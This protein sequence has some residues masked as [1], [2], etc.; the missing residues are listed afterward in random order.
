MSHEC[1]RKGCTRSVSDQFLMCGPDWRLVPPALQRGVYAAYKRGQ[2]LGSQE[3][4]AAQ[5]AVIA[6][7][8]ER[9]PR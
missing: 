8:N 9:N 3:L 6:A 4:A 5:D 1:P 2:G 7:V